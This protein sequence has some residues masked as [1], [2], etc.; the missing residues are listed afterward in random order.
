[1][2]P[3]RGMVADAIMQVQNEL[4]LVLRHQRA[5]RVPLKLGAVVHEEIARH[6]LGVARVDGGASRAC[7]A[8]SQATILQA[9]RGSIRALPDELEGEI[10][11]FRIFFVLKDLKPVRNGLGIS[12]MSTPKGVMSDSLAREQNVGGE[13]LCHVF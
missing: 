1:M 2:T 12:I 9:R 4:H 5:R 7:G 3:P 13:I 10:A 8:K 6:I 11:H